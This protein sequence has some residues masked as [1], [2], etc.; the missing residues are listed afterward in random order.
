MLLKGLVHED[1]KMSVG[2]SNMEISVISS[3][4]TVSLQLLRLTVKVGDGGGQ[5]RCTYYRIIPMTQNI[6]ACVSSAQKQ[7]RGKKHTEISKYIPIEI[8]DD[9]FLIYNF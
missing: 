4:Q 2:F 6:S 8:M 3:Q 7:K 5:K 9:F 1:L